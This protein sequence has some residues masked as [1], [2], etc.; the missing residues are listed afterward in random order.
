MRVVDSHL[1]LWDPAALDYAWLEGPLAHAFSDKNVA[2]EESMR[3]P[4]IVRAPGLVPAG[5]T[6]TIIDSLDFAPTILGLAGVS[7]SDE[8]IAGRDR[9]AALRGAETV[10]D[11]DASLY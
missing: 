4:L 10:D 8:R 2:Y 5:E 9:S 7:T 1:H 11:D 3:L 6:R